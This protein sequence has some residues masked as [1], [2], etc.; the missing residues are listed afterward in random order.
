MGSQRT[1]RLQILAIVGPRK[2]VMVHRTGRVAVGPAKCT[3]VLGFRR[4]ERPLG[5]LVRY[6]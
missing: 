2:P 3:L 1:N 4:A 5:F 6:N